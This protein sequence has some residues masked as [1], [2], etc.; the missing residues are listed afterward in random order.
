[1]L[2][3]LAAALYSAD[4]PA[5]QP[6][7][8][9][10]VPIDLAPGDPAKLSYLEVQ[11]NTVQIFLVAFDDPDGGATLFESQGR[12]RDDAI[13]I[14]QTDPPLI[15]T[16][17]YPLHAFSGELF[18]ASGGRCLTCSDAS[19]EWRRTAVGTVQVYFPNT[20]VAVAEIQLDAGTVPPG[21]YAASVIVLRRLAFG[22]DRVVLANASPAANP[23]FVGHD[24]RGQ[25]VFVDQADA[26]GPVRDD[27]VR[28]EFTEQ[29]LSPQPF[30][31][32]SY[33]VTYR[34][35]QRGAE[36]RC[37]SIGA[38]I[39][40]KAAGCELHSQGR[41]LFSARRDDIGMDR[42]QAFRGEL[43]T[44]VALVPT[45]TNPYRSAGQVIGLRVSM[46]PPGPLGPAADPL[47]GSSAAD[48]SADPIRS[49]TDRPPRRSIAAEQS[50]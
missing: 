9:L 30:V 50:R 43:P 35:P 19:V 8:G 5:L 33:T 36:F 17:F 18:R 4:A 34:D 27:V 3:T 45:V 28:Y 24:L 44:I 2:M 1:M 49:R 13:T 41:V 42:I 10:Y 14:G 31:G 40:Q 46:P 48:A 32:P 11:G 23:S 7:S 21:G 6:E 20:G 37:S 26:G 15:T 25:W 39:G 38:A 12:L 16:G 22:R 29:V 47:S